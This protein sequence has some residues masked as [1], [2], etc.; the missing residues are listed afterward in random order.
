MVLFIYVYYKK[1]N[2]SKNESIQKIVEI[3]KGSLASQQN[4][5]FMRV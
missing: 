3:Q 4:Y 5:E 1:Q 2:R